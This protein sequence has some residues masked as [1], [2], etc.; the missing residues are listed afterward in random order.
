LLRAITLTGPFRE[1][2]QQYM[3]RPQ[4][5]EKN[6]DFFNTYIFQ[7]VATETTGIGGKSTA[8]AFSWRPKNMLTW[9][10]TRVATLV[11]QCQ[12][13][14]IWPFSKWF[15]MR[16]CRLACTSLFGMFLAFL[17]GVGS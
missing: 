2:P 7:L 5:A 10:M 12:I 3:L 11:F 16:K 15:G 9:L 13:P 8:P 14:E 1:A 4:N 6:K 17:S